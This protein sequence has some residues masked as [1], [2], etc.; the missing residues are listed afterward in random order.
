MMNNN[1]NKKKWKQSFVS[2]KGK[3]T[4]Y[5]IYVKYETCSS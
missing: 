4:K 2:F 3:K 5:G 1:K